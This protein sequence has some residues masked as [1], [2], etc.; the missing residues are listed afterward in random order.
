V[1][2]LPSS[3]TS[4]TVGIALQGHPAADLD[5]NGVL[6]DRIAVENDV[7]FR[8]VAQGRLAVVTP[9]RE[10]VDVANCNGCHDEAGNG[11][12]L[13]GSNRTGTAQVCVICH[14][15]N[16]TDVNRRPVPPATTVDGKKEE[17]IDFKRMIHMIHSGSELENPLVIYGFGGSVNDFSHVNFIGN[18]KHCE[19]C[20]VAGSYAT[21]DAHAALP[22][23]IDTGADRSVSTDDLNISPTAA[24]CSACHDSEAALTHMK[25]HGASFHAL[26][27]D[28]N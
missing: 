25:L 11:I 10:V 2:T 12:S 26:D 15:P 8:V 22:T 3:A 5:G 9:R 21:E 20:H 4:G 23:T 13:H 27:A 16:A 6:S 14:N 17:M 7:F 18:R 28:I 24:V 19:T 1:V